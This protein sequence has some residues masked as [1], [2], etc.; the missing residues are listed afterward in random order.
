MGKWASF[1][2]YEW[3]RDSWVYPYN[4]SVPMVF[5]GSSLAIL[6]DEKTHKYPLYS[7]YIGIS[8]DWV[9]WARGTSL[10]IPWNGWIVMVQLVQCTYGVSKKRGK[11]PKMDGEN[12]GTPY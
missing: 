10:P 11:P 6:G 1:C 7:A 8:H 9:R 3:S 2:L 12:N 5:M 4:N